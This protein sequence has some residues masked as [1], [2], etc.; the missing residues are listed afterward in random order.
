MIQILSYSSDK[1]KLELELRKL[2][3]TRVIEGQKF[4]NEA[5]KAL[6]GQL[7]SFFGKNFSH[8]FNLIMSE[9]QQQNELRSLAG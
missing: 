7:A 5:E 1:D 2:L 4:S 8:R 6:S 3:I 9:I